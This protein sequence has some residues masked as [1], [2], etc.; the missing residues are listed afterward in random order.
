MLAAAVELVGISSLP[1][2]SA[3]LL[4]DLYIPSWQED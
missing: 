2:P 3:Y 4:L 1:L